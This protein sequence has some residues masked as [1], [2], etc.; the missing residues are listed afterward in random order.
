MT[1]REIV[2]DWV[3]PAGTGMATVMYFAPSTTV[4]IQRSFLNTFWNSIRGLQ[5]TGTTFTIRTTGRELDET[6]GAL[7]G[8]WSE[9]TV[10]VASGAGGSIPVPDATQALI[11]WR[12]GVIVGSRFVR[13][14][15]FLPGLA[16]GNLQG[17]NLIPSGAS[18]ILAAATAL[19]ASSADLRVW[20]RPI[21]GSGG[22]SQKVTSATVWNEF[23]VLRRRRK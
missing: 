22:S 1:V 23:A 12:T 19:A 21:S 13:G 8:A 6:T 14:R 3:T 11:Q 2:T 20:H 5:S 9:P 17:G 10:F 15:T 18:V 7:T 16:S 4:T